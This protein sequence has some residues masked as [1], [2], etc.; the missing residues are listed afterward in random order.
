MTC[1]PPTT[2]PSPLSPTPLPTAV[3][4]P[5]GSH[6]DGQQPLEITEFA[7]R[8]IHRKAKQ[9]CRTAGFTAADQ[10]DLEQELTLW[11]LQRLDK[12]SPELG[13][14]NVFFTTVIE[15]AC[16]TILRQQTAE[17]RDPARLA[18]SLNALLDDG[19]GG[20]VELGETLS[21]D[22][23]DAMTG[24][25]A[26]GTEERLQMALDLETVIAKLPPHLRDLAQ[27][28][29][30]S[31]I[32]EIAQQT[33]IPRSSINRRVG[34]LRQHFEEAGLRDYLQ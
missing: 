24:R 3:T 16:S 8:L 29:K 32:T 18:C 19:D 33:G 15:R 2:A 5:H 31:S 12:F 11:L 6:G 17:K 14:E 9:L 20:K 21:E 25:S 1:S 23:R 27:R 26:R 34:Q 7:Q 22:G 13:H 30:H 4:A 10:E 28:L